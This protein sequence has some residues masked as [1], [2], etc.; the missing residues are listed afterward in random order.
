M[1]SSRGAP[2]GITLGERVVNDGAFLFPAGYAG[3]DRVATK[4]FDARKS[5]RKMAAVLGAS[6]AYSPP[7]A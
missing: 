2:V 7:N 3:S 4:F 1:R 5:P 6:L